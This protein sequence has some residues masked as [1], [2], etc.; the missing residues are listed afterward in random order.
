MKPLADRIRPQNFKEVFGQKHIIGEGKILDRILKSSLVPNMIFYG[1]PGTGKT[2]VANIIAKRTNKTFYKLN[3]T[4]ASVKDVREITE[5]TNTLMGRSGVLLYLDEIQNFNKKQQQSLLE[6]MENGSI[7]LIAST[8][9]NPY[10]YVYNAILSRSTIFEFKPVENSELI[11]AVNRAV[12]LISEELTSVKIDIT[13]EAKEYAV[14]VSGGDVRKTL[15]SI[16]IAIYSTTR[17]ENGYIYIDLDTMKECTQKNVLNFD[18]D[19]DNHYDILSAFQKSIRGSD[20]DAAILYLAML[21]KGGDLKSIVR[22]L[23]VI[24]AEDIGLAYPQAIQI[25]KACTDAALEL[26]L[27]EARIPLAEAVILL[28]TSPKSNSSITAIDS[29]L[30]DLDSVNIGSIPDYLKDGHYEGAK[31]LGRMQDYK[32]PHNY[33]NHYVE[34]KYLPKNVENRRYYQ[35]GKNK[36]EEK[37]REYWERIKG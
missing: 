35:Y 5:S 12:S 21:I 19:G 11:R 27:P 4:T 23:L 1:P 34:Q 17:N 29:A 33:E 13:D 24:A 15:N 10:F 14:S 26:G 9:E 8:T 22:R 2:T 7:T 3:A 6:F 37:C 31:K 28:A 16:E 25:V 18:K 36:L 32:Y 30:S 20:A